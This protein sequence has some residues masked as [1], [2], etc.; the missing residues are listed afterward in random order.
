M[1]K[2]TANQPK[3]AKP[4]TTTDSSKFVSAKPSRGPK[5]VENKSA[6]PAA[7]LAEAIMAEFIPGFT[8]PVQDTTVSEV[9]LPVVSVEIAPEESAIPA[10]EPTA[11]ISEPKLIDKLREANA[12][13]AAMQPEAPIVP[14][15]SSVVVA[16]GTKTQ[17]IYQLTSRQNSIEGFKLVGSSTQIEICTRDYMNWCKKAKAPKSMQAEYNRVAGLANLKPGECIDPT[18]LFKVEIL[19][20]CKTPAELDS[21]K[22]EFGLTKV[23]P[24]TPTPEQIAEKLTMHQAIADCAKLFAAPTLD[25]R[26][27]QKKPAAAAAISSG[28]QKP[29]NVHHHTS[30]QPQPY[31][32]NLTRPIGWKK[33]PANADTAPIWQVETPF[34]TEFTETQR[35]SGNK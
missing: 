12:L 11:A 27:N 34:G 26:P 28:E 20:V 9:A 2:S 7:A 1:S 3:T 32:I 10:V 22:I 15:P 4:A 21:A 17:G 18:I 14:I 30:G 6:K 16:K 35:N 33:K 31:K 19:K 23:K 8:A 13:L 24:A 29:T 5:L 25:E